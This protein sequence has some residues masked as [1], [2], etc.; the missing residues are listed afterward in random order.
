MSTV[1]LDCQ[2]WVKAP[3]RGKG[4]S[5]EQIYKAEAALNEKLPRKEQVPHWRIRE[6]FYGR[7]GNWKADAYIQLRNA[8][9]RWEARQSAKKRAAI[10]ALC[11]Q[12]Q[13]L[14][15][16]DPDRNQAHIAALDYALQRLS[17]GDT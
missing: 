8:Y 10:E 12:R 7:A 16:T 15:E 17:G 6:A 13:R 14:S 3:S 11:E 1:A 5:G 4:S 9:E 2:G